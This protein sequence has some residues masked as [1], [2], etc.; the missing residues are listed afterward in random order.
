[1]LL[2]CAKLGF[3]PQQLLAA[4]ELVA[5]LA[6][7]APQDLANAAWA[8]GQLGHRDEQLMAA[9]LTG[10][11]QRLAA[12]RQ[13]SSSRSG[14]SLSAQELCNLCWAVAVLDLQQHAQQ[15]LQLAQACSSQWDRTAPN[16]LR[17][18]VP[19]KQ[20]Q[21]L[22]DAF[23]GELQQAVIQEVS[24]VLLACAK[25]GF[26]PQQLP[27]APQLAAM[28]GADSPQG[29]ANAA[30]ACG[31]LGHRDEQLMGA[32][33]TEAQQRLAAAR[34]S[35]SSK[36]ER[37][38]KAQNL[39]N[40]CWAVAVL[41][42]QQHAQQVLQ[43]AHACS[44]QWDSVAPENLRQLW[45]V[46]TWLLDFR[47]AGGQGLQGSLTEQQLQQSQAAW[48]QQMQDTLKQAPTQFQR[49]LFAAVQRLPISWQQQ[50]QMEQLSVG[51]DG[52]TPDGALV[53]DI[54]G[55]TAA[56]VLVAVEADGPT[57]FRQPDGGLMGTT[58]WRNR[59]LAVRGYRLVSVRYSS[60][61]Q[62][63]GDAQLQQ[64]YLLRLLAGVRV[65]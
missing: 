8:C 29:V 62:L 36:H 45:Q 50:R 61:D 35:S 15:V 40:L 33:L 12:L 28:F 48:Q 43:L 34:Q 47:L 46:H 13:G 3:L 14:L 64:Q 21:R 63:K 49:S 1:V 55:R 30:W 17:Q 59:A 38:L 41:D 20:L 9:L 10:A 32:L 5:L 52:V 65:H 25:M 11:Q 54:A 44:S 57:H 6:A 23:V 58:L 53:L 27:A 16:E 37:S 19:T 60:W 7:G 4:P 56:G 24:N 42:L 26:L 39:C 2:A 31:Q 22:L 18:Q 51:R